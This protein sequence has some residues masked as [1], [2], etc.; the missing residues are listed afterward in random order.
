MCPAWGYFLYADYFTCLGYSYNQIADWRKDKTF[1]FLLWHNENSGS[2]TI[3]I[4]LHKGRSVFLC[5]E[6]GVTA[7]KLWR[8]MVI[9]CT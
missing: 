1:P 3:F 6:A 5:L 4:V 7:K 2:I 9:T 8:Y